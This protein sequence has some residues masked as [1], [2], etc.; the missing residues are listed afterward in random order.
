VPEGDKKTGVDV[1]IR[2]RDG[3][4]DVL[5]EEIRLIEAHL[6]ELIRFMLE[7]MGTKEEQRK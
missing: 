5:P 1:S 3:I 6:P 7:E 2:Y 4:D